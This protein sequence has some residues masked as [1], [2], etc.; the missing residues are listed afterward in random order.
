MEINFKVTEVYKRLSSAWDNHRYIIAYGGSSSSKSITILQLLTL[1]ALRNKNKT[2]TLVAESMPV[3]KKTILKD[4]K[5][6]VMQEMYDP[7]SLN[8]QEMIYTFPTGSVFQFVPADDESRFHG[9]RQ[10]VFYVDEIN[11]ISEEVYKQADIRT[12]DKVL[13]SFNPTA[14]FWLA[15][16]FEKEGTYVDHST[17]LD[18]PYL[19][20]AIVTALKSRIGKDKNFTDVYL[21]GKWG[22]LEG[23]IFSEN[24]DWGIVTE[25]PKTYDERILGLDWGFNHPTALI[26]VRILDGEIYLKELL[27][28]S[29]LT[30]QDIA[31]YVV[32][33]TVADSAE[34]KGVEELR[35]LGKNITSAKKGPD[36]VLNGI[37]LMKQYKLHIHR[38]SINLITELRNYKW[39]EDKEKNAVDKPVKAF[40]DA[41]DA[42]RYGISYLLSK[43]NVWFK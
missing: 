10:D 30:N 1:Y 25:I 40:D 32:Y 4:W 36:S 7:K 9:M 28:D 43:R 34:P 14:K 2:I 27:Y 31:P 5:M 15:Y 18:N 12:K 16:D 38:D 24:I 6:I 26:D 41:I 20:D 39:D 21:Y 11:H 29:G 23:L 3:I 17:Y 42:A 33:K 22:S 13:S 37:T 19:D 8:K 35:R